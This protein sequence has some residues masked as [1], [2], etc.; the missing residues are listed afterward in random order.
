M[1]KRIAQLLAAVLCLSLAACGKAESEK[2]TKYEPLIDC[3]ENNDYEGAMEKI[4]GYYEDYKQSHR[5]DGENEDS[6]QPEGGESSA[7]TEP[8]EKTVELT[9]DNWQNYF[10]ILPSTYGV[11]RN[12]FGEF[13][14]LDYV[15]WALFLKPD[16]PQKVT[17]M[18]DVA[19]EYRFTDGYYSWFTYNLETGEFLLQ[20]AATKEECADYGDPDDM[21][22]DLSI[23]YE[24]VSDENGS[25]LVFINNHY[26]ESVTD[27]IYSF[28]GEAWGTMEM[29]RVKGTITVAE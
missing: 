6:S 13:E 23:S 3:L 15:N 7:E 17:G 25:F 20:N 10:E 9:L 11:L 8:Q 19:I 12:S 29:V 14:G 27:N 16:A 18:E 21:N 24:S 22:R 2:Y 26:R 5:G 1:K 28:I 4:N